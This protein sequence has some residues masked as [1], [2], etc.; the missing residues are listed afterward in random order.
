MG[1]ATS[2]DE[3]QTIF[4]FIIYQNFNDGTRRPLTRSESANV[5][6]QLQQ[7]G[8]AQSQRRFQLGQPVLCG[9]RMGV[10][11]SALRLCVSAPM[12]VAAQQESLAR[13]MVADALLALDRI[14]EIIK[15]F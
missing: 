2:W 9:E 10:P 3:E 14:V 11:V 13:K 8:R 6:Q 1:I 7:P 15:A 4:P 5:Y 12:L